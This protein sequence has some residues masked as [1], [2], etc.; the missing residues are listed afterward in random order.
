MANR[1]S[2]VRS[3]AASRS[4]VRRAPVSVPRPKGGA[5][6]PTE[7]PIGIDRGDRAAVSNLLRDV[8]ADQHVLSQKTRMCH[9]NLTSGRFDPLHK[10]FE[11]QYQELA[12]AMDETA[13]RIRML[14]HIA[15]AGLGELARRARLREVVGQSIGGQQA[16]EMLLAD[17]ERVVRSLRDAIAAA[18]GTHDD[19]GSADFFTGLLRAH[20]KTAWMLRSHLTA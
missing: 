16:I 6:V 7:I 11:E 2:T 4:K 8:L 18:D 17:H 13:E 5:A 14:G 9:W 3:R 20:E 12:A 10:M 19:I 15:P 1:S